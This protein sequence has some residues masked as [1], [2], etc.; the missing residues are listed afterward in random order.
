MRRRL[1][2]PG[3]LSSPAQDEVFILWTDSN[4]GGASPPDRGLGDGDRQA[5]LGQRRLVAW[6]PAPA[7]GGIGSPAGDARAGAG[8]STAAL[9]I[10]FPPWWPE[11]RVVAA[12]S[13]RGLVPVPA[14]V[15]FVAIVPAAS[16]S[17][18]GEWFRLSLPS[19][20]FCSPKGD[21]P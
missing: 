16:V 17:V 1:L 13:S 21:E 9:A 20:I 7:G 2:V 14:G 4:G 18:P 6:D 11:E 8:T 19:S 10:V 5:V 12:V 15:R 3:R